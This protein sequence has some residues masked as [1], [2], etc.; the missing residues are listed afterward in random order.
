MAIMDKLTTIA[1]TVGEKAGEAIESSKLAI[2]IKE[3]ERK[4]EAA[5]EEIGNIIIEKLDAGETMDDRIAAQ[6]EK[7]IAAR[8]A[9]EEL[10]ALQQEEK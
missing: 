2:K 1:A 6:Y 9:I 4:I 10:K 8:K 7:V 3:E 5:A